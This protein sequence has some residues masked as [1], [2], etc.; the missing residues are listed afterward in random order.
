GA[1]VFLVV[2]VELALLITEEHARLGAVIVKGCNKQVRVAGP[3]HVAPGRPVAANAAD[4][5]E[6]AYF[7]AHVAE[8]K[9][10]TV[11]RSYLV[12]MFRLAVRWRCGGGDDTDADSSQRQQQ[13]L[14]RICG[15][16]GDVPVGCE[17][18]SADSHN[19]QP[20]AASRSVSLTQVSSSPSNT[21]SAASN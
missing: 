18:R 10:V 12:A 1:Q 15:S 3:L 19:N 9:G 21:A 4:V 11:Y 6:Q 7:V 13:P 5:R 20:L 14:A 8:H 16:H 2:Q 17:G